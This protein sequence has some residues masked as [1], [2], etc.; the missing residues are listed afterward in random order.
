MDVSGQGEREGSARRSAVGA[1]LTVP[2]SVSGHRGPA[3]RR[4]VARSVLVGPVPVAS[5]SPRCLQLRPA[6]GRRVAVG[7][8]A[9]RPARI[10]V[11]ALSAGVMPSQ[12]QRPRSMSVPNPRLVPTQLHC[13]ARA[14]Q[15]HR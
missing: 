7:V 14:A 5:Q 10:G 15:A 12:R 9:T 4:V 3:V 8:G 1:V 6:R 11:E 13:R 2:L